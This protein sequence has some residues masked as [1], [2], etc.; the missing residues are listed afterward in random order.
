M[1]IPDSVYRHLG[2]YVYLLVDP[3]DESVFY[4]GKG[5][6]S[7]A[8]THL[9]DVH[10]SEKLQLIRDVR[11][12][13]LEP[14]VEILSHKIPDQET[15][16]RVEAAA[17]DLL[18][19]TALTNVVRG[20]KSTET[21]RASLEELVAIYQKRPIKILEPSVLIR[22]SQKYRYGM[23]PVGLYDATRAAWRIGPKRERVE[24]AFAVHSDV[25][26]EVYRVVQWFPAGTTLRGDHPG[27]LEYEGRWE[28]V[29][30]VAEP[31]VRKRYI[32]GYVGGWFAKG[33]QNPIRY[34]NLG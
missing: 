26:R 21:G 25:V 13:G 20:W 5:K 2:H 29:G 6:G 34:L 33:A 30:K 10:D 8:L 27:G 17:I 18:G 19:V 31:A 11:K 7:R 16:L 22:I 12:Q 24:L 1:R 28:F 14:R 9:T 4:I 15:A 23:G 32:D 3:R